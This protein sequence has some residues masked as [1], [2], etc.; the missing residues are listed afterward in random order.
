MSYRRSTLPYNDGASGK[1]ARK[2]R[3]IQCKAKPQT[4]PSPP[5]PQKQNKNKNSN[6][7]KNQANEQ[8]N[9]CA[10]PKHKKNT[11]KNK[12][13]P[14]TT[15]TKKQTNKQT[16]NCIGSWCHSQTRNSQQH[17]IWRT[18]MLI[19]YQPTSENNSPQSTT[20]EMCFEPL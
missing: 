19:T 18:D 3:N 4:K 9:M 6:N 2:Q 13:K 10:Q 17:L 7:T 14:T 16:K 5:K 11:K 8:T 15:T 1:I 12:T 20:A